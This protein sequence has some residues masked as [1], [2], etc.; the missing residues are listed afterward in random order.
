[1][2]EQRCSVAHRFV[3]HTE[4]AIEAHSLYVSGSYLF[5]AFNDIVALLRRRNFIRACFNFT[6]SYSGR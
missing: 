2:Q 4:A 6:I 1:M 3:K 5:V